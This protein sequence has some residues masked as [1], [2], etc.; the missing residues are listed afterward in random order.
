M[1]WQAEAYVGPPP[2]KRHVKS[3]QA[4]ATPATDGTTIVA[5]FPGGLA[6]FDGNGRL[7]WKSDLGRLNPGLFGDATSEWGHGSS[8][9]IAE[10]RRELVVV[11]GY[12]VRSYDPQDGRELWRFKDEAEVK[13]PSPF[14]SDGLIVFAG[15]YRGRPLYAIRSGAAGDVSVAEGVPSGPF[16]AW[17]TEP[18]GPYTVTPLAYR[19]RLRHGRAR[20]RHP[21]HRQP[22]ALRAHAGASLRDRRRGAEGRGVAAGGGCS[23]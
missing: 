19:G 13:T 15:G 4:N 16:L 11:G 8:P 22:H 12:Y 6:A 5:V 1:L 7:L 18:G 10:G 21:R 14:A 17:R 23:G 2:A 3:S 20:V 9:V